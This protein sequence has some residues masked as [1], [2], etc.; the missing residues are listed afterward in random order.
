MSHREYLYNVQEEIKL[1]D[2]KHPVCSRL[3]NN[4]RMQ[5]NEK[6][7]EKALDAAA[8]QIRL[9]VGDDG[10]DV[11]IFVHG[12]TA[13]RIE[14]YA[15]DHY[16][17][18]FLAGPGE[19]HIPVSNKKTY[20]WMDG[21][22]AA[23]T[24][25]T[26]HPR[27]YSPDIIRI[28]FPYNA[29]MSVLDISGDVKPPQKDQLPHKTLLTYGSSITHGSFAQ[30]AN[31]SYAPRLADLLAMDHIN[32][33]SAGS[34][35]CES[36]I[37]DYIANADWDSCTLEMG[38]NM[39]GFELEDFKQRVRYM[40]ETIGGKEQTKPVYCLDMFR[41]FMDLP[42]HDGSKT[43]AFR[44][45]VKSACEELGGPQ[46]HFISIAEVPNWHGLGADLL[47][48]NDSGMEEMAQYLYKQITV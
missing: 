11:T 24:L 41:H 35:Q 16:L 2:Y 38:I 25:A 14:M 17:W 13:Q 1:P 28:C 20:P 30:T 22:R 31:N 46:T 9:D 33:G 40:V 47:H 43:Q 5:L 32:L 37:A 42:S 26:L 45:I 34:A 23:Q 3:P 4:V 29:C 15:G 48:P 19:H 44:E 21:E 6:A 36:A 39:G 12:D 18:N 27:R 8:V 7:Q 10:G